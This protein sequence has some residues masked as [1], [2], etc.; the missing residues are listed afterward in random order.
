MNA[1]SDAKSMSDDEDEQFS[2]ELAMATIEHFTD[3]DVL[4][5]LIKLM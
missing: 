2:E 1:F 5:L 4:L 3:Y